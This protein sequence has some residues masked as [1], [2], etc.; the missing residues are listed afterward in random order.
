MLSLRQSFGFLSRYFPWSCSVFWACAIRIW[1]VEAPGTCLNPGFWFLYWAICCIPSLC[2]AGWIF[3]HTLSAKWLL[4][5]FPLKSSCAHHEDSGTCRQILALVASSC[6]MAL[7]ETQVVTLC[8]R[9]SCQVFA[10]FGARPFRYS[11]GASCH[12]VVEG[13]MDFPQVISSWSFLLILL[14]WLLS[15]ILKIKLALDPW[16]W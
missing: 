14:R 7:Q 5:C 11:V 16:L 10:G 3:P 2:L 12:H 15:M 9:R 6:E 4:P 1:I 8:T 13:F